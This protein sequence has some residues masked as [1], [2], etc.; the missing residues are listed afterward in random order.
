[1]DRSISYAEGVIFSDDSLVQLTKTPFTVQA[2][3]K[4]LGER[5]AVG[6]TRREEALHQAQAEREL[7]AGRYDPADIQIESSKGRLDALLIAVII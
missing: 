6:K 3:I 5:M 7:P 1:M 4:R 2:H